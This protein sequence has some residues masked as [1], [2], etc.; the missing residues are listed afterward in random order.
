MTSA[1]LKNRSQFVGLQDLF[2]V[3]VR[4]YKRKGKG[5]GSRYPIQGRPGDIGKQRNQ[6]QNF[7]T[8][9]MDAVIVNLVDTTATPKMTKLVTWIRFELVT[10]DNYKETSRGDA[11]PAPL[12]W[13]RL[14]QTPAFSKI[15]T[16]S[17][18]RKVWTSPL[19]LLVVRS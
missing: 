9:G 10:Q 17:A 1:R 16:I 4:G 7:I 6:I 11:V 8:A 13:R 12:L 3:K 2:L 5:A 18:L 14:C 15:P 19:L